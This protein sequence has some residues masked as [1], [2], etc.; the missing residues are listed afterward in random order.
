MGTDTAEL[1]ATG[2]RKGLSCHPLI[3]GSFPKECAPVGPTQAPPSNR[4]VGPSPLQILSLQ[5]GP[6]T[7]GK[8]AGRPGDPE[9]WQALTQATAEVSVT[10]GLSSAHVSA[11]AARTSIHPTSEEM[12]G[13]PS[14][15]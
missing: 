10:M 4:E 14:C 2:A 7:P 8:W 1:R 13:L 12:A 11:G 9:G 3:L 6:A 15:P 5:P